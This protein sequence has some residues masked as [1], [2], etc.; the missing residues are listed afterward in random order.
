MDIVN[1]N[2]CDSGDSISENSESSVNT[3]SETDDDESDV[4]DMELEAEEVYR[5]GMHRKTEDLYHPE[6]FSQEVEARYEWVKILRQ[7]FFKLCFDYGYEI[8]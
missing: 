6:L 7:I 2:D 5:D 4:D 8:N 3:P 1:E